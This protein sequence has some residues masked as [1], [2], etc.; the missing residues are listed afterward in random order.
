MNLLEVTQSTAAPAFAKYLRSA[1]K[2]VRSEMASYFR[3]KPAP[4]LSVTV[5]SPYKATVTID[6]QNWMRPETID[7]VDEMFKDALKRA[8]V[9]GHIHQLEVG[10]A[11]GSEFVEAMLSG[12]KP[13]MSLKAE[14]F[15][16]TLE[17][18]ITFKQIVSKRG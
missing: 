16:P 13:G 8:D 14:A 12:L 7:D 1:E 10:A 6:F 3:H 11:H 17:Y 4:K 9:N 5:D 15:F 2:R 18:V